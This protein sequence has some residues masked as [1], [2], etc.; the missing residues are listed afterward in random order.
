MRVPEIRRCK[1]AYWLCDRNLADAFAGTGAEASVEQVE[2]WQ[3]ALDERETGVE[4]AEEDMDEVAFEQDLRGAVGFK[5]KTVRDKSGK[6]RR[7][8]REQTLSAPV[9]ALLTEANVAF[10]EADIAG[11]IAKLKEVIKLEPAVRSAWATLA[12]CFNELN[13]PERALQSRIMEAHLTHHPIALW[14]ELATSSRA[15]GFNQQA[16][17][18][19]SKAIT[20]STEKDRV[21]V[22]DIMWERGQLLE[23]LDEPRRAA[24]SYLQMLHH[25]P[26]NQS[27]IRQL[28]PLLYQ[29]EMIDRAIQILQQ[30]EEWN[31]DAFPDPLLD[32]AMMDESVG[33]D[34]RSTYESSE[35]VT[36][37][38][39][40]LRAGRPLEALH[41]IRRGARWLDGRSAETFWNDVTAD[42][43]EFDESREEGNREGEFGRRIDLAPTHYLEPEFRF[44]IAVARARMGDSREAKRHFDVWQRDAHIIE[45]IDHYSD[46]A[47]EYARMGAMERASEEARASWYNDALDI[48]SNVIQ[49]RQSGQ[50]YGEDPEA[51]IG[52]YKRS[53][54]CYMGLNDYNRAKEWL[55]RGE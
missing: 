46:M 44:Q 25:R 15:M 7:A 16:I 37:A 29:I 1:S 43:R 9:R 48:T 54:M 35:V 19:L 18:C 13:E 6:V 17:Y 52:D 5:R 27:I 51:I 30:C 55:Q 28:I 11:A 33:P 41:T 53:A 24:Q 23:E 47:E 4:V 39:L 10:V 40:L 32:P 8:P 36:L 26:Q 49:T 50:D 34:V 21:D 22:I 2:R 3:S 14:E 20:S 31:M 42:D 38:D 12:L 45:H